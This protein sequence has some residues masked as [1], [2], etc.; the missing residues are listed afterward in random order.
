MDQFLVGEINLKTKLSILALGDVL[1]RAVF[2]GIKFRGLDEEIYDEIPAIYLEENLFGFRIIL[3]GFSENIDTNGFW[4]NIFPSTAIGEDFET[5][6]ISNYIKNI[7]I[8]KLSNDIRI[9]I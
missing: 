4:L 8:N 6:N 3:Q 5:I 2:G 1:S 9:V 7:L